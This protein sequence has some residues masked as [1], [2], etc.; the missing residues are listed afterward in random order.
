MNPIN[1]ELKDFLNLVRLPARFNKEQTAGY[2]GFEP[3]HIVA[4]SRGVTGDAYEESL[5]IYFG[6][7]VAD[8]LTSV[9]INF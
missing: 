2:L 1:D 8:L 4:L 3:D 9:R 7:L 5:E 6:P